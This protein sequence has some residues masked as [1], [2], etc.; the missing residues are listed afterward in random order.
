MVTPGN[1]T[2]PIEKIVR[3]ELRFCVTDKYL[4]IQWHKLGFGGQ[5]QSK[6]LLAHH[7]SSRQV[8]KVTG[9]TWHFFTRLIFTESSTTNARRVLLSVSRITFL[10]VRSCSFRQFRSSRLSRSYSASFFAAEKLS[11]DALENMPTESTFSHTHNINKY[12][13]S[14]AGVPERFLKPDWTNSILKFSFSH[15]LLNKLST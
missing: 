2:T 14:E 10:A 11:S 4:V 7:T 1:N 6:N 13:T 12:T 5:P 9:Y 15:I 3:Q 8:I